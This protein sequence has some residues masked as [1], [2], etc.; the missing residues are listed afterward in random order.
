MSNPL[1]CETHCC[2]ELETVNIPGTSGLSAFSYTAADFVVPAL[3]GNITINVLNTEFMAVGEVVFVE[4]AGLFEVVSIVSVT[5]VELQYLNV[6]SNTASG[7]TISFPALVTPSAEAGAAGAAGGNSF[8]TTT[9]GFTVPAVG[10]NV[11]VPDGFVHVAST[12]WMGV[13][14]I[15]FISD[16]TDFGSFRVVSITNPTAFVAEYLGFTGEAAPGVTI[17]SGA[18]VSPGGTQPALAVPLPTALTDNSTGTASN[19]I[20]A[21]VGISTLT[22]PLTSLA[23]GLS[24]S[25]LDLLTGYVLGYR[26]KL[27]SF[28]FVTTIV[29]A[30]AGASQ[31]FNLEIGSTNVTGGV[32]TVNLTSTDTIGEV[33]AGTAI[34]AANVGTAADSISLEMAVGGT[35]FTSGSG[36]FLIRVQSMD[37]A[38]AVASLAEHTNDL[39]AS[40]T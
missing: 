32:L 24:T 33:T 20:A 37:T 4:T 7:N 18:S 13:G 19:T 34:T 15:V 35:A 25:A 36:Y 23:T 14:Q 16:G 38:D 8:T 1:G 29:G 5:Q 9:A 6:A 39:I 27:L 22:I 30:G 40:L 10:A 28:D 2:P 26:F 31:V 21:G 11:S 12:S 3:G 17:D